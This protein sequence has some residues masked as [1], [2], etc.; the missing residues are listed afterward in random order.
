MYGNTLTRSL[1]AFG[2][3]IRR[4]HHGARWVRDRIDKQSP[5]QM[6]LPWTSWTCIDYLRRTVKP[7]TRVFEWGGGGSTLFWA[8][9]GCHVVCVE[10]N[11]YWKGQIEQ[12]IAK[13]MPESAGKVQIRFVPAE[14]AQPDAVRAYVEAVKDG[15]PWDIILVDGLEESYVSRMDCLK[16]TPSAIKPD[17]FVLLDD[18]WRPRYDEA[19]TIM[20][21]FDQTKFWG[22]GPARMGCTRTDMYRRHR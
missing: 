2:Q 11:E 10:S 1:D 7:G 8:R 18:S 6:G 12:Q 15:A 19:P 16:M 20:A 4:P 21:G 22:L 13:A 14:T 5:I 3:M 9:M 17:G